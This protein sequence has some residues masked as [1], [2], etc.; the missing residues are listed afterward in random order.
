MTVLTAA[1]VL[2]ACTGQP[3]DNPARGEITVAADE[4]LQPL[5]EALCRAYSGVYTDAKFN[6][7]YK[8]EQ[9]AIRTLLRD[10]ARIVFATRDLTEQEKTALSQQAV[11]TRTQHIATDG[12]ALII[13]KGNTDSLITMPELNGIFTGEIKRW[14]QLKGGNQTGP[15]V[16]VFDNSNSSNLNYMLNR[17]SI[18]NLNQLKLFSVQSNKQVIEYVRKN[19][20]AVGFIGVNWISD[21]DEPL[22]RELS[23]DLRVMGV[24]EKGSP[25]G[26]ADYYQPFQRNLGLETYPLR[27]KIYIISREMHSGLGGGLMTYIARDVGSLVIEKTGLW[28]AIPYNREVYMKK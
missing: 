16:L 2:A 8:P 18:K 28:P 10:S 27:R 15:I 19:P 9:E 22:S 4:S 14:S 25:A 6:R 12:I 5:V 13:N 1:I 7:L 21:G 23:Q 26:I 11:Q 20:T 17:F 24:S 3:K